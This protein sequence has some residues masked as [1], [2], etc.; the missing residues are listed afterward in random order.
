MQSDAL[1][2][3][4]RSEASA[5]PEAPSR[6]SAGPAG[7]TR[8][9]RAPANSGPRASRAASAQRASQPRRRQAPL[10]SEPARKAGL[11]DVSTRLRDAWLVQPGIY[12]I[13]H[14]WL[15]DVMPFHWRERARGRGYWRRRT[16]IGGFLLGGLFLAVLVGDLGFSAAQQIAGV[17]ASAAGGSSAQQ[18]STPGSVII[19]PLNNSGGT[20]TP[21]PLTYT[22]GVWVSD[23]MPAGGSVTVYVRVSDNGAPVAK[24][25]VYIQTLVGGG[26]G[27]RLG[28]LTTNAAGM[29]STQLR[30]GAGSGTP[31]FLTA[32]VLIDGKSY[33]GA[34]TFV[35]Y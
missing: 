33:S 6:T 28:P 13:V 29:A 17:F 14:N 35:A 22:V 21:G 9:G 15:A 3:S 12:D 24:A 25:R 20:P 26:Y 10:E 16:I 27:P 30:Y 1:L 5:S 4:I 7:P 31:V 2:T 18:Q 34:Y 23:T 8:V 11:E 32:T 19:S